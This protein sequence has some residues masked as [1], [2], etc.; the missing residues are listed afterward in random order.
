MRWMVKSMVFVCMAG[1]Q[2]A[3]GEGG[4][5]NVMMK[6]KNVEVERGS[7]LVRALAGRR[8]VRSFSGREVGI[9]AIGELVWAAQGVSSAR[10]YRTAPSAGALYPLETYVATR[11]GVYQYV[12]REHALVVRGTN[13]VRGALARAAYGQSFVGR[14]PVVVIFTAVYERETVKYGARGVMYTHMEVGH[15]AQN[16]MLRAVELGLGTVAVGA[17]EERGVREAVG[18]GREETPVYLIPVG[19][20]GE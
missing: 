2:A 7:A 15:A 12:P 10:G 18:L 1:I 9:E 17:F 14:A 5:S 11:E 8:S 19:Y 20:A 13:D 6:L 4:E 3:C 16:L